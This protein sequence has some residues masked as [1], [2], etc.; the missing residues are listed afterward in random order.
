[1]SCN[2]WP[3][4]LPD[5][6]LR[7]DCDHSGVSRNTCKL[8]CKDNYK[9][10][11]EIFQCTNDGGWFPTNRPECIDDGSLTLKI[12]PAVVVTI[13]VLFL[14]GFF[15][16]NASK[17][18]QAKRRAHDEDV[19]GRNANALR[20]PQ[21]YMISTDNRPGKLRKED[22]AYK[23]EKE[24]KAKPRS[25]DKMSKQAK[26]KRRRSRKF[27][28]KDKKSRRRQS[29]GKT[30]RKSF[31]RK[32]ISVSLRKRNT[33]F[34]SRITKKR[35][36]KGPRRVVGN[37]Q[38]VGESSVCGDIHDAYGSS[39]SFSESSSSC[40][41]SCSANC[42]SFCNERLS[43]GDIIE[44]ST[45]PKKI[46]PPRPPAPEN[47]NKT[48]LENIAENLHGA[49]IST[50]N[51]ERIIT[52]SSDCTSKASD[53]DSDKGSHKNRAEQS[54][55][56]HK[57]ENNKNKSRRPVEKTK[58]N[59]YTEKSSHKNPYNNYPVAASDR[60][61]QDLEHDYRRSGHIYDGGVYHPQYHP[62]KSY[63]I[64]PFRKPNSEKEQREDDKKESPH[65]KPERGRTSGGI[66]YYSIKP[67]KGDSKSETKR[68]KK[69]SRSRSKQKNSRN[70][71]TKAKSKQTSSKREK[72]SKSGGGTSAH[73]LGSRKKRQSKQKDKKREEKRA[74]PSYDTS[75]D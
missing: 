45:P 10:S 37:P 46:P 63:P 23:K 53:E 2:G 13:V 55:E 4:A 50:I 65:S 3:L 36:R 21:T 19:E 38:G 7:I 6:G 8:R 62:V 61:Y 43:D 30:I 9:P 49:D 64:K 17:R 47:Q 33:L 11:N 58:E 60:Q 72:N 25:M 42:S 1:M 67:D 12:V 5:N 73:E 54:Q 69:D 24:K 44:T 75:S 28:V 18:C 71:T 16:A 52:V 40:C 51:Q 15:V 22:E 48:S 32:K 31:K 39:T 20:E 68:K 70:Q 59:R 74:K 41:Q 56:S 34:R 26:S 35:W 66:K 29:L 57:K 27:S 14:I